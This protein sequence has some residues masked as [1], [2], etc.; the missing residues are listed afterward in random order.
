M[1]SV[2]I[3]KRKNK[4]GN[5]YILVWELRIAGE[6][7]WGSESCGPSKTFADQRRIEVLEDL[8]AGRS[9]KPKIQ[10]ITI[11]S[12]AKEC[13]DNSQKTKAKS[14]HRNFDAPAVSHFAKWF[15]NK[16]LGMVDTN[17]LF[18]WRDALIADGYGNNTVRMRLRA[19]SAALGWAKERGYLAEN[20]FDRLRRKSSLF[21]PAKDASR[22][23]SPGEVEKLIYALPQDQAKAV[24]FI[25]HTGLRHG[26]ILDLDWKHVHRPKTGPWTAEVYSRK[27]GAHRVIELDPKAV[28]IMGAPNDSGRVFPGATQTWLGKA[29]RA[30]AGGWGPVRVHDLRHTWATNFMYRHGNIFRLMVEGGWT[31]IQSA[32]VYQHLRKQDEPVEYQPF[33]YYCRTKA[34]SAATLKTG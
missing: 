16:L 15:G 6:R 28:E 20:P 14:T 9:P 33:P 4:N 2:W 5:N 19:F 21:P 13:L 10:I 23:L 8:H 32:A 34:R 17:A 7:V 31:S 29:V 3:S 22:Y 24:Y 27:T 18:G 25:L 26:E 1:P 12:F 11:G 30:A